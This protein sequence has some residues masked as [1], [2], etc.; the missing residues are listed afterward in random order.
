MKHWSDILTDIPEDFE[1]NGCTCFP[2]QWTIPWLLSDK[3]RFRFALSCRVHDWLYAEQAVDGESIT[4][5]QADQVLRQGVRQQCGWLTAWVMYRGVR[6]FGAKAWREAK[7][8]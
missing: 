5:L 7:G 4:R 8:L 1:D 3:R 2:D 6:W